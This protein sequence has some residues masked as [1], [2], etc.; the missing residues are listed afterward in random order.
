[1]SEWKE[2]KISEFAEVIAGGTPSTKEPTYY[3]GNIPWITPKDLT[4]YAFRYIGRGERNITEEG[5]NN[6]SAK[7]LPPNTILLTS[8]APIGYLAISSNQL[9][10][11]QG[12]KNLVV[13]KSKA[14]PLFIYYL[15]KSNVEYIKSQGS[16]TTF[17]EISGA[18]TKELRFKL[19]DVPTQKTIAEILSSLDDKIELNNQTNANLE[20][21]AQAIFKRWFI[22]FEFPDENG[23]PYK[24]SGGKMVESELGLVPEGFKLVKL[25]EMIDIKHGFAFKSQFFSDVETDNLLL[26]PGNFKIGG[27]FKID[28]YKYYCGMPPQD[29]VLNENDLIVT[30]TDLSKAGDTLGYPAFVP[31]IKNKKLLHNQR[32]GKVI[33]KTTIQ[34]KCFIYE[35]LK[36][37]GYRTHILGSATGST[38][39][40][41]APSR[42]LEFK[43]VLPCSKTLELYER[44]VQNS[45]QLQ[46][47]NFKE[48]REL[49]CLLNIL[50]PK[51]TSGQISIE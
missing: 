19:P 23:N 43:T 31:A 26:T 8:R 14:D 38:V 22:D 9:A 28:K 39:K 51:L 6:S 16:G 5:L 45:Y 18:V 36:G 47:N 48:S 27:G 1:M 21:L 33:F 11:N 30:M 42:I 46:Q 10:T 24:S 49:V 2:Y 34:P 15:L 3:N 12:F 13:N 20:A 37:V 25:Q 41:T 40:H 7:L 44:V 4:N 35:T 50:L 29:Y 32:L 17:A